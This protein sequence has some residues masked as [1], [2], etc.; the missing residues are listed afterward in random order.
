MPTR[1][2]PKRVFDAEVV[3]GLASGVVTSA[4][5]DLRQGIVGVEALLFVASS[6]ISTAD[7]GFEFAISPDNVTFGS[8]ADNPAILT[9]TFSL[10][11][12]EGW[13]TVPVPLVLAP[14]V[15]FRVSG[16]G[17]NPTDTRVTADILLREEITFSAVA[18]LSAYRFYA[19]TT[20]IALSFI[21]T[22]A[23]GQALSNPVCATV[24][25]IA[26]DGRRRPLTA[27]APDST[28]FTYLLSQG[29]YPGTRFERG[30]LLV[31][32]GSA[33]HHTSGFTVTVLPHL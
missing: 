6:F 11:N 2:V 25:W 24:T 16:T 21:V 32:V 12:P 3:S 20:G 1:L 33:V 30:Q 4:A 22:G 19:G 31:S 23:D 17:S 5:L 13:H 29:D 28:V 14:Y 27:E 15:K 10:T 7:V 26:S 18:P 9:S 8:F